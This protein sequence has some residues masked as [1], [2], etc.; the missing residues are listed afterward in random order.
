MKPVVVLGL[1]ALALAACGTMKG[2]RAISGAMIGGG[3]GLVSGGVGVLVGAILG[4]GAGYVM[5]PEQINLGEPL[6][7]Q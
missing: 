7:R 2:D 5:S 1:A 4:G 6:W 3:V